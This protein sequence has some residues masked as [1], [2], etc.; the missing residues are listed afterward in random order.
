MEVSLL[1][2]GYGESVLVH[3]GHGEW[4]VVDSFLGADHEPAALTYLQG[5]DVD[6]STA[7]KTIVATHWHDDHV[8][9][10]AKLVAAC[11]SARFCCATA[12]GADEFLEVVGGLA[13]WHQGGP[14]LG[15]RE[16]RS[17][18][19]ALRRMRR[20]P[21]W[22]TANRR[23]IGDNQCEVSS[24]SPDDAAFDAFLRSV[25]SLVAHAGDEIGRLRGVSRNQL[26]VALWV[27]C[28]DAICLLGSDVEKRAW[29][30]ILDSRERPGQRASVFKVPHHGSRNADVPDVWDGLL[31]PERFAILAPWRRGARTLPGRNDVER[32]LSRTSHAY[33]STGRA[34]GG[35]KRHG[36]VAKTMGRFNVRISR[37]S[38]LPSMVRLRRP[39]V[40]GFWR[41][42][43][44][45]SA[46]HL[47]DLA[48]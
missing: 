30:T 28:G 47:R 44:F 41:V 36:M 11:G 34:S 40:G 33:A 15:L 31:A 24:L 22:A 21:V 12:L 16:I 42:D 20:Q 5:M 14:M 35:L 2:P 26:S 39:R 6:P 1:G 18:F 46:C 10:M 25:G 7:V 48:A 9:G 45:G 8:R 27:R 17:V 38:G 37:D 29:K 23:L 13:S 43:L 19:S 3:A 32:M 4:L